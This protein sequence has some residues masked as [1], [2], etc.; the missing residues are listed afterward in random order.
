MIKFFRQY[1]Q[2]MIKETKVFKYLLYAIGEIALVVIGIFIALQLN[3]WK[4][5]VNDRKLEQVHLQNIKEDLQ[6]QLELIEAQMTH[7]SIATL[8]ADSAFS[9]F[10]GAVSIV[11]LENLLYGAFKLGYRKTFV[12]SDASFSELLNTGGM[13]LIRDLDL[14]KAFMRYY[15]QLS[16]TSRVINTNNGLIDAMFNTPSTNNSPMFSLDEYGQLD[17]TV[18]L[19]GQ[20]RYRLK[21]SIIARQDLCRIALLSCEKQRIATIAL[22]SEVDEKI[23][24]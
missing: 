17:T 18:A 11:Q 2:T 20:E 1:R 6:L 14:R 23:V 22:I 8:R 19:T 9:Y 4:A 7:D 5:D 15:Q 16:Y 21:Q 10:S 12:E 24:Q 13:S 3:A